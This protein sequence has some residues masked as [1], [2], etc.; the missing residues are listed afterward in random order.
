MQLPNS[1]NTATAPSPQPNFRLVATTNS[2]IT[3]GVVTEIR[4][5]LDGSVD[6]DDRL[7]LAHPMSNCDA[8][9]G[10]S[11]QCHKCPR[12]HDFLCARLSFT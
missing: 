6:V 1:A 2:S 4:C 5:S 9:E 8:P 11:T 3:A 7:P 10:A 12:V